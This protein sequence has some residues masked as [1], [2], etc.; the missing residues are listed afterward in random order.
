METPLRR[1]LIV[2]DSL[3]DREVYRRF[4]TSDRGH[5]YELIET[6]SGAEGIGLCRRHRP[7][8]CC[9]TTACPIWMG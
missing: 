8:A 5:R 9:S 2:D 7:T 6:E 3:E 4:L 1:V